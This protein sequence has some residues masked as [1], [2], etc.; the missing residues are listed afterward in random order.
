MAWC[1]RHGA[2]RAR[3]CRQPAHHRSSTRQSCARCDLFWHE[4]C[5]AFRPGSSRRPPCRMRILHP[6]NGPSAGSG[7]QDRPTP[8]ARAQGPR[9]RSGATRT[10]P[11]QLLFSSASARATAQVCDEHLSAARAAWPSSPHCSSGF[12][13]PGNRFALARLRAPNRLRA[14]GA[15]AGSGSVCALPSGPCHSDVRGP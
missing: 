2:R 15:R 8:T 11:P 9:D 4:A 1:P 3:A 6:P 10:S 13:L 5:R 14:A 12:I 7:R